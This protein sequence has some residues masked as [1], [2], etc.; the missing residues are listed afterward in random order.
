MTNDQPTHEVEDLKKA[1]SDAF[2]AHLPPEWAELQVTFRASSTVC[3]LELGGST[4]SGKQLLIS[5]PQELSGLLRQLRAAMYEPGVGT[6][7]SLRLTLRPGSDADFEFNFTEDPK[8]SPPV[9]PTV[10]ALDHEAFPR[11]VDHVPSWL[12]ERL[13]EAAASDNNVPASDP[14]PEVDTSDE[15]GRTPTSRPGGLGPEGQRELLDELASVLLDSAPDDWALIV[16]EYMCVGRH[17]ELR[18]GVKDSNGQPIG[19]EPP[20]DVDGIFW[21]LRVGMYREGDGAW[22]STFFRM[23]RPRTYEVFYN[24]NNEPPWNAEAE[25]FAK[26][27]E[28][29]PRS[30]ERI[31]D[32]FRK[33]LAEA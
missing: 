19:W 13:E 24:W 21:K 3:Q 14:G 5:P 8:W 15:V 27:L 11:D 31:P 30:A 4:S 28:L 17:V 12:A 20:R 6:W 1:I 26:E 22:L 16:L 25:S 33:R 9:P 18:V 7:F 23:R 32:W 29:F 10:F 2:A